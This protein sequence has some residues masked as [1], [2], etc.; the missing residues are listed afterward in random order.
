MWVKRFMTNVRRTLKP[1]QKWTSRAASK[2]KNAC[3]VVSSEEDGSRSEGVWLSLV[4][5][6]I[7]RRT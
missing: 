1:K 3:I 2:R 4:S 6:G 7:G 5:I